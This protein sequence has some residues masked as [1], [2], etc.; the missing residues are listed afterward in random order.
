MNKLKLNQDKTEFILFWNSVHQNKMLRNSIT[1]SESNIGSS[2]YLRNLRFTLTKNLAWRDMSI[3]FANP[4]TSSL[5][6][7]DIW[8][9]VSQLKQQK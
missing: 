8:D 3:N 7:L 1:F 5:E 2:K 9:Q 4:V 6:T